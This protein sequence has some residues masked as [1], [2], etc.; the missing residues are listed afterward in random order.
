M[1]DPYVL[2]PAGTF[3]GRSAGDRVGLPADAVHHLSRVLRL[4]DGAHVVAADGAGMVVHGQVGGGAMRLAE[5]PTSVPTPRPRVSV[6]QALGK[7]RKHDEVVRVLTELG[8]D[9]IV[10]VTSGRTVVDLGTKADK[11]RSRWRAIATAACEQSRRPWLPRLDGPVPVHE[12]ADGLDGRPCLLAHVGGTDDP[13][14]AAQQ[15]MAGGTSE[16]V[17]AVGP[18]G[19]WTAPEVDAVR[20]AGAVTVGLGPTVLRTEHAATALAAVVLAASGR[21]GRPDRGDLPS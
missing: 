16:L 3:D 7:G 13:L 18:E 15:A 8:V 19:G 11:V 10:A 17:L 2:V 9:E 4:R 1:P 20:A 14:V 21:M 12:L 5:D 6:W